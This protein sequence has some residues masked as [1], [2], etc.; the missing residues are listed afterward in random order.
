MTHSGEGG[1][2][3]APSPDKQHS[4]GVR[5]HA[6]HNGFLDFYER[7]TGHGRKRGGKKE[8]I[9][10]SKSVSHFENRVRHRIDSRADIRLLL[11]RDSETR[12]YWG[13]VCIY[14]PI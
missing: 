11:T 9:D 6:Y 10:T 3:H 13:G 14:A 8:E 1:G 7:S 2:L 5:V 4:V 12:V